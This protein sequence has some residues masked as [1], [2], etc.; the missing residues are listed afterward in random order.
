MRVDN[1]AR[2][3]GILG[4]S[5]IYYNKKVFCLFSL[6]SPHLGDSNEHTQYTVFNIKKERSH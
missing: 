6:E 5:L 4:I 1:S 2:S 3:G